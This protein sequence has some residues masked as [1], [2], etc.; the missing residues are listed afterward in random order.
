MLKRL[1]SS[2]RQYD[3]LKL[4]TWSTICHLVKDSSLD[5]K[6]ESHGPIVAN[7]NSDNVNQNDKL[8]L[9]D[10]DTLEA[11]K[12]LHLDYIPCVLNQ[13]SCMS[14]NCNF[15]SGNLPSEPSTY[16]GVVNLSSYQLS[17]SELSLLSKGLT[18]VNTPNTPDMGVLFE[19]LQKFHTSLKRKLA[20]DKLNLERMG[21]VPT[22]L[23]THQ[24]GNNLISNNTPFSHQ[25]F[26]NPSKW[27]PVGPAVLESMC[28]QN[29]NSLETSEPTHLKRSN[30]KKTEF[31]A[32]RTLR[33]NNQ[34]IIKKAD[35]GSA[36]VIQ[37]RSDYISEGL[38]QLNDRTFYQQQP[39][40]LT[41]KHIEKVSCK[42]NSMLERGE[43]SK[44]CAE[45]LIIDHPRTA[46]FYL[47]PKIHKGKI[48]PPGRPIV[49]ANECPT[50]RISQF[51]DH[52]IQ[53]LVPKLK[54]YIRD[55]GHFLW[56]LNQLSLPKN[57]ILCTL[58]VTSLYTNIPNKEGIYAV[59]QSLSR[60]RH[61]MDNPTNNSICELLELVLTCNNF[62]FDNKHYLQVGGTAMGTKLAPSFANIYMGWFEDTF[63]YTYKLQPLI[64]KRYIDD[65]F[66]VWQHGPEQLNEFVHHLNSKHETI[67]FTEE[68]SI[69]S[70]N[71]LDITVNLDNNGQITTDLYCKPT[72]SHNYLL[73]SSEH[74]RHILR[75]I[76]YSQLLRV[77]RI[78]SN[79]TDFRK[80]ALMLS[81]HFIRRGYPKNLVK[82]ALA[83]AE[84]QDRDNLL[85][86]NAP[87][88]KRP[89][90]EKDDETR[91][92]LISTHNPANPP[93]REIIENNWSLLEKS[94]TTRFLS[95]AKIIFGQR[96]NKNLSDQLVRASTKNVTHITSNVQR[97][98]CNRSLKCRYC[99]ILNY[100]GTL[101]SKTNGRNF[102]CMKKVNCQSSNLIYVITCTHCGIQY[103]GQTKNRL[104]TR[105]QGHFND[106]EHNRD[107]TVARHLNKCQPKDLLNKPKF[108][109]TV[110]SFIP[111]H[112]DSIEA[113]IHRD[114]EEK[115]WMHRLSTITPL[116]LN[117]MD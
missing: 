108:T 68:S 86:K 5:L 106:I 40:D 35:K 38:R 8:F 107:T 18:F 61:H 89:N 44:K 65:I 77:R 50:E 21:P 2:L 36:V 49:S 70:I 34:I 88:Y 51:V 79:I 76:P 112:P 87:E 52:F 25:K 46:N 1:N 26:K 30:I 98:T 84:L 93:L 90:E 41:A 20:L 62:Q 11:L 28:F 63:V 19:D 115:R 114:R 55:S 9:D 71:F 69:K 43:I 48:P 78:C 95:D 54:S 32:L 102:Q 47:L 85:L 22:T 13:F 23:D 45:Y 12:Q 3:E 24:S 17:D 66:M 73:F 100:T 53:P 27:N 64:W 37:N 6:S 110:I 72:D 82:T 39:T 59:R 42:V 57:T 80:N 58:D 33:S 105:F 81:S 111:A 16:S 83:K 15:N 74:P 103:V 56:I 109:I 97:N 91:F 31:D 116:G 117:L 99:P 113:K 4:V 101:V 60:T 10:L 104:L 67:K 7:M 75:G 94:K 14:A 96:R 29:E 92:Y